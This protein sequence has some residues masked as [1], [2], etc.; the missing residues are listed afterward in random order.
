MCGEGGGIAG[1]RRS[2]VETGQLSILQ[3]FS[4]CRNVELDEIHDGRGA[5]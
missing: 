5:E 4:W 3:L 1:L 2:I